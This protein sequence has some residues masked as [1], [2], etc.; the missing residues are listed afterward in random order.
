MSTKTVLASAI[1]S[2]W[3]DNP[4]EGELKEQ[5]RH[6]RAAFR[7][8]W[9]KIILTDHCKGNW[10]VECLENQIKMFW[11]ESLK[12]KKSIHLIWKDISNQRI[13]ILLFQNVQTGWGN[14]NMK[15]WEI[16]EKWKI[17]NFSSV[18]WYEISC[19]SFSNGTSLQ[20]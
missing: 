10:N 2:E 13:Q 14:W 7:I 3:Q 5:Q 8:C 16:K 20:Y 18:P 15:R 6:S 12:K 17:D 11:F 1:T 9:G 4:A 19:L